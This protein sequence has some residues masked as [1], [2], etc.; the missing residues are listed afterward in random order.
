MGSVAYNHPIGRK[1]TTYIPLIVLAFVWGLYNP[2]H[3]LQ[4]PEKS[5]D[6]KNQTG[7]HWPEVEK[8][9][10]QEQLPVTLPEARPHHRGGGRGGMGPMTVA[11][12]QHYLDKEVGCEQDIAL[13]PQQKRRKVSQTSG[14]EQNT[15]FLA[16]VSLKIFSKIQGHTDWLEIVEVA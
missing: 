9:E 1:N 5:I 13:E 14:F 8:L 3:P 2:Y 4:E 7:D 16:Y 12:L 15:V 10:L 6:I 11:T